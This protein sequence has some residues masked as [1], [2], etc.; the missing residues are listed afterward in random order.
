MSNDQALESKIRIVLVETSHPGNIGA[1]ARAMKN[2]GL[3]RLYLVAPEDFPNEK[4]VFRA[5][6]AA[7]VLDQVVVCPT[8]QE[9]IGGCSLVLGTSARQRK[10]PWPLVTPKIAAERVVAHRLDPADI[11]VVFGRESKRLK[12]EELQQCHFHVNIPTSEAYSSLNLAMAVQV[13]AYE[14]FCANTESET[15]IVW[16]QPAATSDA[17]EHFFAHLEDTLES[18]GFHDPDNP[19]Q[20]MTR[21]R[22]LFLRIN[23][24]KMELSILRGF[25]RAVSEAIRK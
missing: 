24:D 2:M 11:A 22:R 25:L 1:A 19:R 16:D 7:D 4:A 15:A 14:I 3:S 10:I 8:L 18:V 17:L 12:N 21:L 5:A 13:L 9:A 20:L 6:S 23:P